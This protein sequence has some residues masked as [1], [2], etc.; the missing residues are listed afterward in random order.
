MHKLRHDCLHEANMAR[1]EW[2]CPTPWPQRDSTAEQED[3]ASI[4]PA[5]QLKNIIDEKDQTHW[6]A[7][8][9]R[10]ERRPQSIICKHGA[11]LSWY[12]RA[13]HDAC[14][15]ITEDPACICRQGPEIVTSQL[16]AMYVWLELS[17]KVAKILVQEQNLDSL[18]WLHVL[19]A[20]IL[21]TSEIS[22]ESQGVK[23]QWNTQQKARDINNGTVLAIII[24]GDEPMIAKLMS[25]WK[26]SP[27]T[28][29]SGKVKR[30]IKDQGIL[31][32]VNE[33][34][35]ARIM[36]AIEKTIYIETYSIYMWYATPG[37]KIFSWILHLIKE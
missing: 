1:P 33:A 6:R 31:S 8:G 29:W 14:R 22:S 12:S 13:V 30:Q 28:C 24:G 4:P 21:M 32:K 9:S 17:P 37:D 16:Q 11:S 18:D 5:E 10:G 25:I 35:M 19:I 20:I 2:R 27:L 7:T 3:R 15:C 26:N 34:Y 23:C 36:E